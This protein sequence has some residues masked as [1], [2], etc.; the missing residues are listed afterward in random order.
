MQSLQNP[1]PTD[2]VTPNLRRART[3]PPPV[4]PHPYNYAA[5]TTRTASTPPTVPPK[6]PVVNLSSRPPRPASEPQLVPPSVDEESEVE[7]EAE[8]ESEREPEP[9]PSVVE[10]PP[11]DAQEDDAE[12]AELAAVLAMSQAET[13]RQEKLKEKMLSQEEADLAQALE[14]SM[15]MNSWHNSYSS[16]LGEH[17]TTAAGSSSGPSG[18]SAEEYPSLDY[19]DDAAFARLLAAE[20]QDE[21]PT[22]TQ[23][24]FN[25]RNGIA[26]GLF[27]P[28]Q[29]SDAP[30]KLLA[31]GSVGPPTPENGDLPVYSPRRPPA[32][33]PG[34]S[35]LSA[36]EEFARQLALEEEVLA[37]E[38]KVEN[39]PPR[40]PPD[41]PT[42]SEP[43]PHPIDVTS[44]LTDLPR[45][46]PGGTELTW[47]DPQES[48]VLLIQAGRP[49]SADA[50]N[51]RSPSGLLYPPETVR[52]VSSGSLSEDSDGRPM[53]G[54]QFLDSDLLRGV[55]I[56]FVA[57][58]I[59]PD[60]VPMSGSMPNIISLPYGRCP[61]LHLQ[62]PTWRHLLKLMARLS[63]T[64]IE[65]T[66]EAL[67]VTR[68]SQM[69]LRT[70][71]QFVRP[72]H[73]S[74]D[75]RAVLWFT[76]DHPVPTG[77]PHARKYTN[78]D[79]DIL[80]WSYTLSSLPALL[81]DGSDTMLS[82][83]YTIP[84]S[85]AVPFPALPITFPNMAMYLQAA[86]E[87]S[88]KYMSDSSSGMRKLAKM[89]ETCYPNIE[90]ANGDDG[91]RSRMGGLFKKVI[92]RGGRRDKSKKG[93][94][95]NEDTYELVTPFVLD[96]YGP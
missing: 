7:L 33:L 80:P 63:G 42:Y 61:P 81:R 55:S 70:V 50:T 40:D 77:L 38:S 15:S 10:Q 6:P 78:G 39:E 64:R 68:S 46:K 11:R 62:A 16:A 8:P 86:L 48:P 20:E 43:K 13:L 92:G 30:D 79:V 60:M 19:M 28:P 85:A 59:T 88:R 69:H 32:S 96:D 93:K 57:P 21:E 37:R 29:K 58:S 76:I 3:A 36:D 66:V 5:P 71:V 47:V 75:W 91:E 72:H 74:S 95:G 52:G 23:P 49:A 2:Y 17:T 56:G 1:W 24:T 89:V 41:L 31:N 45:I 53:G 26:N 73:A 54:N 94:G 27:P 84:S 67:A 65:P 9:E 18:P 51:F 35:S 34:E 83:F 14:A 82:K 90:Q 44:E 87:E 4:P 12:L 22:P 25:K